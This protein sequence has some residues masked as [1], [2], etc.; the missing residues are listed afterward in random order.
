MRFFTV[1]MPIL[2]GSKSFRN[3]IS[4]ALPSDIILILILLIRD[5]QVSS[6]NPHSAIGYVL[7][8]EQSSHMT[9]QRVY[10]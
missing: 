3:L 7:E 6:S 2:V 5:D 10:V 9:M 8:S 1:I 4:I